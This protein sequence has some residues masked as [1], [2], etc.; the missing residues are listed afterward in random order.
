MILKEYYPFSVVKDI[1]FKKFVH[2]LNPDYSLP[3]RKTLST[4]LLLV[5]YNKTYQ[6]IQSDIAVNAQ[7]I[8]HY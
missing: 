8:S 3:S 6:K 2:M 5:L 4:S 7:Y 1:E